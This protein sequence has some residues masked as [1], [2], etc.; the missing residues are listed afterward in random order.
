MPTVPKACSRCGGSGFV[1]DE[2][3]PCS[4]CGGLG[5]TQMAYLNAME[6]DDLWWGDLYREMEA[7]DEMARELRVEC[8][9]C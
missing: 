9:G 4:K 2:D 1:V 3:G 8:G 5:C 6:V 7:R